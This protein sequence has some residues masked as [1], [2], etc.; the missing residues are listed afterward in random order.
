MLRL[1]LVCLAD[2]VDGALGPSVILVREEFG[3]RLAVV[4]DTHGCGGHLNTPDRAQFADCQTAVL[5]GV[6]EGE[7]FGTQRTPF[8]KVALRGRF[9]RCRRLLH[10]LIKGGD[11][12]GECDEELVVVCCFHEEEPI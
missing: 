12:C 11:C 6:D 3:E 9:V 5:L 7:S 10:R 4:A 8:A 2:F 1:C